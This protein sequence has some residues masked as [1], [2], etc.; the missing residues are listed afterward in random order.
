MKRKLL[1][2]SL[3][4]I[5]LSGII[6]LTN[7]KEDPPPPAPC[8][9]PDP[10]K[11]KTTIKIDE[12][13]TIKLTAEVI[14][15]A[16]YKWTGPNNY[17]STDTNPVITSATVDM[18]GEYKCVVTVGCDSK[19][20]ST[21]VSVYGQ[22][23]DTR[24]DENGNAQFYKTIKIGT[25]T[26]MAENLKWKPADLAS[27]WKIYGDQIIYGKTYGTLYNYD[28]S[29]L[30][31]AGL[32]GWRVPTEQ[33]WQTLIDYLGGQYVAGS[34]LKEAADANPAH[35]V[36]PNT[37]ATNT[38]GFTAFGSGYF[39]V[40]HNMGFLD[41]NNVAYYWTSTAYTSFM[42][43]YYIRGDNFWTYRDIAD[44]QNFYAVR[45]VKYQ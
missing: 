21:F 18:T 13:G 45:L 31:A 14:D 41:I 40:A 5:S 39:D 7:C 25:Q 17:S 19:P 24:G 42:V 27:K 28:L 32:K 20:A 12:G 16:T 1:L 38:S 10:P 22:I 37:G 2:I 9:P 36:A 43:I 34:K 35:W 6:T 8:V 44:K 11:V 23:E 4:I 26:W 3:L 29:K 30:A 33:D 15:N